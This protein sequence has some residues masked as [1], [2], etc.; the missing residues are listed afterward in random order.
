MSLKIQPYRA[1]YLA[2]SLAYATVGHVMHP[3]ILCCSPDATLAEVARMMTAH[4]V[5][6]IAVMGISHDQRGESLA[7]GIISDL[8]L[9]E[10]GVDGHAGKTAA[11]LARQ[12]IISVPPAIPVRDAAQLML[13]HGA[14][15]IV[16]VD[17]D[18]Q[19][20]VGILSTLDIAR[21]LAWDDA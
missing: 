11:S 5:H 21:I 6:C 14:A 12:P 4:R 17:S 10:A 9:L 2:P 8:D 15:H 20:P 18:T 7:W 3:G 13:T 1:D 16:V 19:H